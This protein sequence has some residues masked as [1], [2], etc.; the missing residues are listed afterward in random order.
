ISTL[1]IIGFI[2]VLLYL[3]MGLDDFIWDI[4]SLIKRRK[5]KKSR[6]DFKKLRTTPPKVLAMTIG[7]WNE[8][9]VIGA[10]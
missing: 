1:Y 6:L 3:V 4:F 10:V 5:Y 8:S 9:A 2:L 7:A